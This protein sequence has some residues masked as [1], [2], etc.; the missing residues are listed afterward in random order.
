[1]LDANAPADLVETRR[2]AFEGIA[3]ITAHYSEGRA[4]VDPIPDSTFLQTPDQLS[5]AYKSDWRATLGL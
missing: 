2:K 1:M 3:H 4:V 5:A